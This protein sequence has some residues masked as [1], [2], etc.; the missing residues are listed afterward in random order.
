MRAWQIVSKSGGYMTHKNNDRDGWTR[1]AGLAVSG[2]ALALLGGCATHVANLPAGMNPQPAAHQMQMPEGAI[3]SIQ[4]PLV[5]A[6][7][8]LAQLNEEYA[9]RYNDFLNH[10]FSSCGNSSFTNRYVPLLAEHSTYYAAELKTILGRYMDIDRV[11]LEPFVLDYAQGRFINRPV[12]EAPGVSTLIIELYEL[13]SAM[14]ETVGS[15]YTPTFNIRTAASQ[16]PETCG[17]LVMVAGHHPFYK[18]QADDCRDLTVRDAPAFAPLHYYSAKTAPLTDYPKHKKALQAGFV[19]TSESVWEKNQ[20]KYLKLSTEEGF[21]ATS[22]TIQNDTSDWIARMA[23]HALEQ[24]DLPAVYRQS[25]A[26]YVRRYDPA[27][28]ERAANQAPQP[29]DARNLAIIEKLLGAEN[30]W[31]LAQDDALQQSILNGNYGR[32]FRQSRRLLA[33][34]YAKA[35]GLGWMQV[36]AVLAGGFSSGLFGGA[37]AY[38]PMALSSHVINTE[39]LFAQ[40]SESLSQALLQELVPGAELRAKAIDVTIE[41]MKTSISGESQDDIHRQLQAIYKKLRK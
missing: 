17:N 1:P 13:P 31:L 40:R 35:Q 30:D 41:G 21:M 23:V 20:D 12:L 6:P 34:G 24:I 37:T 11:R 8:A 2:V 25:L 10:P 19:T 26:G 28:A 38:N 15:G 29:N 14:T 22:D 9:C 16:S 7:A 18:P 5:A 32:S 27:L 4:F 39:A 33:D 3:V 36:G